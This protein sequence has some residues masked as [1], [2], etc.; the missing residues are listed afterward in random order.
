MIESRTVSI[1]VPGSVAFSMFSD[2]AA[3]STARAGS[4]DP[5]HDSTSIGDAVEC[6]GA[7]PTANRTRPICRQPSDG[8]P[9]APSANE[10]V[11]FAPSAKR[12]RDRRGVEPVD[13]VERGA[14]V[15]LLED[16]EGDPDREIALEAA[17]TAG[18]F[19]P[20][21]GRGGHALISRHRRSG[22]QRIAECS[23]RPAVVESSTSAS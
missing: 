13:G 18:A 2:L 4:N 15:F 8:A 22:A 21:R 7:L 23:N 10:P 14:M 9:F 20:G 11:R 6:G 17:Q 3:I 19:G 5:A 16:R 1:N 12:E